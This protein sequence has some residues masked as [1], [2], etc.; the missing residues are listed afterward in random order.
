[1]LILGRA[2][3]GAGA[4]ALFSG[5]MNIIGLAVPIWGRP[6]YIAVL[7]SMFGIASVV[8]P[9]LG[10]VLTDKASW[11]WC[12]WINL[13]LGALAFFI[14]LI[15]FKP[16]PQKAGSSLTLRQKFAEFDILGAV[17]LIC[18][19]VCLLLALQ[20]GGTTYAWH[21]SKIY[22]LFIG[23]GLIVSLFA[24]VQLRRGD[25]ATIP[26]KIFL[27]QRTMFVS[28]VFAALFTMA[29]YTHLYYLPFYFQ[30]VKGTTAES[31]GIR[32]IP[33]LV[34]QTLSSIVTGGAIMVIG[35]YAPFMW[36]GAAVFTIGCGMLYTLQ[37]GSG[38][39]MWIGYQ[40]LTG[41]GLGASIQIPFLAAQ[42]VLTPRDLPIGSKLLLLPPCRSVLTRTDAIIVFF[43]TLGG[44]IS[45]PIAQN[46]FSN[47]LG[48][49]LVKYAPGV[50]PA[51]VI[52]AGATHI[53][54]V[55]PPA[56]LPGT[57]VAYNR[58]VTRTFILPIAVA[59]LGFVVS[60]FVSFILRLT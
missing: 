21:D 55:V 1:M 44:V 60:C 22:G 59:G 40:I 14:V 8:G 33:Y 17:L 46:L 30:A 56:Q 27:G 35:S 13:P 48:T 43:N 38:T 37:V 26:P 31:S 54:E 4:S 58:A 18:A 36:V 39:G 9:L 10:G 16:P 7:S 53:R 25:K 20:W 23:F 42:V 29:I 2:V 19:I 57:L 15:F 28:S 5:S 45:I 41:I 12:F 11:R 3:A 32:I 51:T 49:E 52:A 47:A 50:N 24:Y 34:S 6:L